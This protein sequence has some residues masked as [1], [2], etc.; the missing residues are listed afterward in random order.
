M[1]KILNL[2]ICLPIFLLSACDVHEWPDNPEQLPLVIALD[3]DKLYL[4]DTNMTPW[5]HYYDGSE[6]VEKGYGEEY[7][8]RLENGSKRYVIRI[9]PVSQKQRTAQQHVIEY[10]IEKDLKHG[11]EHEIP[12]DLAPGDYD[13]MV[14][15]DMNPVGWSGDYFYTVENFAEISLQ[16][17]HHGNCEWRDAFRGT[18]RVSIQPYILDRGTDHIE[19]EMK[20][21]LARFE[22]I[23]TDLK[24]FVDKELEYLMSEATTRGEIAPTRVNID[25]YKIVI[26]YSGYMP[27]TYNMYTDRPVD[28][29]VGVSFE[30]KINPL[31]EKEASLGFDYVF[32]NGKES[33][34]TVQVGIYKG[35]ELLAMSRSFNVPLKRSHNTVF[36]GSFLM[37]DASGGI[38][39]NP[40]FDGNHNIEIE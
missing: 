33:A 1:K 10:I 23:T 14:W 38:T 21:P 18:T 3:Y 30:S 24:E 16:G 26:Y 22:L 29:A 39:I 25:A 9:Y 32:V 4:F 13:I 17:K 40:D 36:K 35:D 28:S 6:T 20:R 31:D 15:S 7:D 19:V 34:V 27:N 12:V 11:Y 5:E 2:I 37:E 8:N